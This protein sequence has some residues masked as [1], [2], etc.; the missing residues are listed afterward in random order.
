MYKVKKLGCEP[1]ALERTKRVGEALVRDL[2]KQMAED[3][4]IFDNKI[5]VASPALADGDGPILPFRRWAAPVLRTGSAN[6]LVLDRLRRNVTD[7]R[8]GRRQGFVGSTTSSTGVVIT[9]MSAP[10]RTTVIGSW[11][12]MAS[13]S[14]RRWSA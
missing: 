7:S 5:Y 1:E 4:V 14:M 11:C 2:R 13:A 3:N 6:D 12:P 8:F 10:L 9:S